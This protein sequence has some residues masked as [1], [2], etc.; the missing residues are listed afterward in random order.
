MSNHVIRL[1]AVRDAMWA[2]SSAGHN[3]SYNWS[4]DP[5]SLRLVESSA[6]EMIDN[7]IELLKKGIG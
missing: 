7:V 5:K 1:T 3:N 2:I 4:D 6:M